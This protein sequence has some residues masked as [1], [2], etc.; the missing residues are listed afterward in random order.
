VNEAKKEA[1]LEEANI[2]VFTSL[3][4]K[5]RPHSTPVW[6][7][8][9]NGE[10]IISVGKDEQKHKNV[11]RNPNVSVVIDRRQMPYYAVMIYGTAEIG[12]ALS[13][14]DRLRLAVRYLGAD[15][16]QRYAE[17]TK[18]EESVTLRIR[19]R[20]MIDYDPMPGS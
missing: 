12:P 9:D 2:I 1:L 20:K 17:M 19:P 14:E 18:G 6:Y 8:Y 5:G 4:A 15:L 3:D 16:G 11:A 13:Q 10:I 7:L